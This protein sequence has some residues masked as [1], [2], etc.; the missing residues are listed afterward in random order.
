M[1]CTVAKFSKAFLHFK[2]TVSLNF[3]QDSYEIGTSIHENN[4]C[5]EVLSS[6]AVSELIRIMSPVAFKGI[7][8]Q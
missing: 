5:V 7:V 6:S 1:L 3:F 4:F 8:I 2:E